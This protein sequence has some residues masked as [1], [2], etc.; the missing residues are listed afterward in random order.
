MMSQLCASDILAYDYCGYG[1]SSGTAS[2]ENCYESIE[3]G[4]IPW[5]YE[6][7]GKKKAMVFLMVY[8]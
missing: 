5:S 3:A 4:E 8:I 1:L 6:S 2:E 7:Y